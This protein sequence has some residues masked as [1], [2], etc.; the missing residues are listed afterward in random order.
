MSAETVVPLCTKYD[1]SA[2]R[3]CGQ[4]CKVDPATGEYLGACSKH[5]G[6][7]K[8]RATMKARQEVESAR[9]ITAYKQEQDRYAAET[10]RRREVRSPLIAALVAVGVKYDFTSQ[11]PAVTHS[12]MIP[13]EHFD[14][15]LKA[16]ELLKA[17]DDPHTSLAEL[18][19]D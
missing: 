16:L 17:F 12:V 15:L 9:R 7:M 3:R 8:R 11:S 4:P 14:R 6:I 1:R 10:V 19:E 18:A 13:E 5:L 2:Y